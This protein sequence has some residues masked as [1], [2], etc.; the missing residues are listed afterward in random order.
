[1]RQGFELTH[2]ET[3]NLIGCNLHIAPLEQVP[4]LGSPDGRAL[5]REAVEAVGADIVIADPYLA[6]FRAA[7]ENDNVAVRAMLDAL[8]Y[9]V[10]MPCR[11]GIII[12]DHQSK[13]ATGIPGQE[14]YQRGAIS[15][16]DWACSTL[17]LRAIKAPIGQSGIFREIIFDKWRYG[18]KP[19][20]P[21]RLRRDETTGQHVVHENQM[22]PVLVQEVLADLEGETNKTALTNAVIESC[23]CSKHVARDIIDAAVAE[24][25]I[26]ITQGAGNR[27]IFRLPS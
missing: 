23:G 11:C 3:A 26:Q 18:R 16:R 12:A 24:G 8:K 2:P 25:L 21:V 20:S 22:A 15:K 7:P 13:G 1:M 19:D 17:T 27:Q 5:L 14:L 10:L 4:D 6:L 9:E